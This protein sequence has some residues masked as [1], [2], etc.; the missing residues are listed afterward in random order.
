MIR[1]T[2]SNTL[3][4]EVV[5]FAS[6][7]APKP[8]RSL[9]SDTEQ[10]STHPHQDSQSSNIWSHEQPTLPNQVTSKE[11]TLRSRSKRPI[12]LNVCQRG[13]PMRE[14]LLSAGNSR[15]AWRFVVGGLIWGQSIDLPS[16]YLLPTHHAKIN[17]KANS[18]PPQCGLVNTHN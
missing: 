17:G 16:L 13:R 18:S 5:L 12:A 6:S 7:K 11:R 10:R 15:T 9:W 8:S 4:L 1:N 2:K 14:L 3:P